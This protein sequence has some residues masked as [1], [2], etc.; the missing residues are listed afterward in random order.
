MNIDPT[1]TELQ[2]PRLPMQLSDKR[3]NPSYPG[4]DGWEE[5][6][7]KQADS[8]SVGQVIM[9]EEIQCPEGQLD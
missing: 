3:P 5:M 4:A 8:H 1:F 6:R 9:V 2:V 7:G